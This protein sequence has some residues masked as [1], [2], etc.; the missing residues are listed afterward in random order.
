MFC[1]V[2]VGSHQSIVPQCSDLAEK[3]LLAPI[4]NAG[5][6]R[7]FS[8]QNLIITSRRARLLLTN[9]GKKLLLKY[10]RS[11]FTEEE[12]DM[13]LVEAS[14]DWCTEKLRRMRKQ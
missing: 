6:E 14:I 11:L 13:I 1:G 12:I 3:Y 7:V 4:Q 2:L 10:T 5:V 8:Q 9:V